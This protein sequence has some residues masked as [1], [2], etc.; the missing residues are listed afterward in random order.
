MPMMSHDMMTCRPLL[1]HRMTG[2]G[3][4]N[5]SAVIEHRGIQGLVLVGNNAC[6]G[7]EVV[8]SWTLDTLNVRW[9]NER[10]VVESAGCLPAKDRERVGIVGY[11][12][13]LIEILR[14]ARPGYGC[15][16]RRTRADRDIIAGTGRI[17][18]RGIR[19]PPR[20]LEM[21]SI[22]GDSGRNLQLII[23]GTAVR[24]DW[25]CDC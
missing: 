17:P 3:R 19:H 13:W 8:R 11:A 9:V 12:G 20:V 25:K 24:P 6:H 21:L 23:L 2:G 18:R 7:N 16:F 5:Q 10:R 15:N 14:A 22:R 1:H 4:P